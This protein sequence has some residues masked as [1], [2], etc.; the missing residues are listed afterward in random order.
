MYARPAP[1][2]L[3]S[4]GRVCPC[5]PEKIFTVA[6]PTVDRTM[7]GRLFPAL[8]VALLLVVSGCLASAPGADLPEPESPQEPPE[9]PATYPDPPEEIR[10]EVVL[11]RA[12]EYETAWL[13]N[14]IRGMDCRV[15]DLALTG[16]TATA[17]QE[18]LNRSAEGAY[19]RVSHPFG[20]QA[21]SSHVD[22]ATE[23]IYY[24]S[25]DRIVRVSGDEVPTVGC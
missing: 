7:R 19:I 17:E 4:A 2:P 23:A 12:Y 25:Q 14:A 1:N 16:T 15:S 3:C 9:G 5:D 21:G 11:E 24:V 18:V 20:Y 6:S 8:A 10:E 13:E 22:G